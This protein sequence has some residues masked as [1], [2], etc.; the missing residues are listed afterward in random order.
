MTP[1][2]VRMTA[3]GYG[4][5]ISPDGKGSDERDQ[6]INTGMETKMMKNANKK[7]PSKQSNMEKAR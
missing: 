5:R 7:P 6:V 3:N 1:I 4:V 2:R